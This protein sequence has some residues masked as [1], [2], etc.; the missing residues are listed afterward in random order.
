MERFFMHY[1]RR[2]LLE[3][4]FNREKQVFATPT[5]TPKEVVESP[6]LQAR[7]WFQDVE[8][9]ELGTKIKH[10]GPIARL[11]ESPMSIARR[12]PRKGEHTNEVLRK[13]LAMNDKDIADLRASGV[14]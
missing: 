10:P 12:A 6:H 5:D 9:P 4:S 8:Y 3:M 14:I 2:E 7:G 13:V 11:P 1:T